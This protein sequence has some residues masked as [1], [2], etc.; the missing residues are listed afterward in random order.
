MRV[1]AALGIAVLA[2]R[3]VLFGPDWNISTIIR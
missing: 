1:D 2:G 3:L